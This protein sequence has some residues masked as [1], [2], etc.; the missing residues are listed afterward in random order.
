MPLDYHLN[1]SL[2]K[3]FFSKKIEFFEKFVDDWQGTN[4]KTHLLGTNVPID[5]SMLGSALKITSLG[6]KTSTAPTFPQRGHWNSVLC[7]RLNLDTYHAYLV[8]CKDFWRRQEDRHTY[9][10]LLTQQPTFSHIFFILYF[11]LISLILILLFRG[12][13]SYH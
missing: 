10:S 2:F 5:A 1:S 11:Y 7:S 8:N 3:N 4:D 12:V 13:Y 6:W 9:T